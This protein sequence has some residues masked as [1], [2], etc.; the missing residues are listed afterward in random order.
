MVQGMFEKYLEIHRRK[1][2]GHESV[3]I[4]QGVQ[5][6]KNASVMAGL[7]PVERV[8]LEGSSPVNLSQLTLRTVEEANEFLRSNWARELGPNK[9]SYQN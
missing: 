9:V 1:V 3:P 8:F 7:E 5:P 2:R 4:Q 6:S